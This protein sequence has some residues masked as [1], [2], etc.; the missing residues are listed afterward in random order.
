MSAQSL[1]LPLELMDLI[2]QQLIDDLSFATCA[3]V[4]VLSKAIHK[5]TL[6]TLW[7]TMYWI[8]YQDGTSYDKAEVERKWKIFKGSKGAKHIK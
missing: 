5:A 4:N 6:K 7:T 1:K 2:A 8:P 3:N